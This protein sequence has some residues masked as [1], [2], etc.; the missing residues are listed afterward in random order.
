MFKNT[1]NQNFFLIKKILK[2]SLKN[3]LKNYNKSQI[4]DK[5]INK[6]QKSENLEKLQNVIFFYLKLL[7]KKKCPL[8]KNASP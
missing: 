6:S 8:T 1:E 2:K 4:N 3:V 7:K 5:N